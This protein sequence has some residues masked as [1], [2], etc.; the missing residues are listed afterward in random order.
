MDDQRKNHIDPK[1]TLQ[2]NRS[3]QLQTH[4][5][6]TYDVENTNDTNKRRGL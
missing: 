1:R 5:V 2:R 6:P 4:K 3:K